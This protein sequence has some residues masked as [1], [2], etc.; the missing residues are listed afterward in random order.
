M[1]EHEAPLRA[2]VTGSCAFYFPYLCFNNLT[3]IIIL[4]LLR[5]SMRC[6]AVRC[7]R[8][9]VSGATSARLRSA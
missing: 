5:G 9:S 1:R 6:D 2:K 8:V 4:F 7:E 3:L